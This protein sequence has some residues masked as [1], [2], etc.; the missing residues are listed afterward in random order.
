VECLSHGLLRRLSCAGISKG[1]ATVI[2]RNAGFAGI[3]RAKYPAAAALQEADIADPS[4]ID[5]LA[6]NGF[7]D[8]LYA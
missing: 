1:L 8:R 2:S 6:R 7:I 5:K 3:S 4:F